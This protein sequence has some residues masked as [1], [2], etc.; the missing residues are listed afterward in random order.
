[1]DK[2]GYKS[3]RKLAC[4]CDPGCLLLEDAR[5]AERFFS[6]SG[7]VVII[8]MLYLMN[9]HV[10]MAQ[11]HLDC[12]ALLGSFRAALLSTCFN[13]ALGRSACCTLARYFWSHT[14]GPKYENYDVGR[15]FTIGSFVRSG[16]LLL[17]MCHGRSLEPLLGRSWGSVIVRRNRTSRGGPCRVLC[18][19]TRRAGCMLRPLFVAQQFMLHDFGHVICSICL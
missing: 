11:Q 12:L 16:R 8:L 18:C 13:L 14:Q 3:V 7:C 19:W 17:G 10:Y 5:N 4:E 9:P 1:V 2:G 6:E 15:C